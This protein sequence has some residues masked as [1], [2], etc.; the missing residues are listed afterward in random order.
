MTARLASA[1]EISVT[2]AAAAVVRPVRPPCLKGIT[3]PAAEERFLGLQ[4]TPSS[5]LPRCWISSFKEVLA[6]WMFLFF[7]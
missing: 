2:A 7:H 3:K 6:L 5:F 1:A 4:K